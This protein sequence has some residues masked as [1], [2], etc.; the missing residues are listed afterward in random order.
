MKSKSA[1]QIIE[2][3][4]PDLRVVD[5]PFKVEKSAVERARPGVSIEELRKKYL[6]EELAEELYALSAD[7]ADEHDNDGGIIVT[8]VRAKRT[9]ADPADD[10]G[11][12]TVIASRSGNIIG[13][14]G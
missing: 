8:S 12:R 11:P 14:Q 5:Q 10:P 4:L 1:E 2:E 13:V 7:S 3:N 6:G 9:P